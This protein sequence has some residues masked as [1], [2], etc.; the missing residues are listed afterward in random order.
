MAR[1][2][3]LLGYGNP[4]LDIQVNGTVEFLNKYD[5]RPNNAILAEEKHKPMF[6]DMVD[7]FKDTEYIPGGATQNAIKV[8]Q[9]IIGI[10]NATTFFGCISKDKFGMIL[11][12]KAREAGVNVKYQYTDK[13]GTGTCGVIVTA[14]NRSLCANL[15]AANCFTEDHLDNPENWKLVEKAEFFYIAGFPLTVCPPAILRIAKHACEK[16]KVFCMNLSAPFLC[17]FYKEPMLQVLPYV[18][19][20]FGNESEAEAFAKENNFNTTDVKEIAQKITEWKKENKNR[21]RTVVIT[22]GQDPTIVA[23][24]GKVEEY[25]VIP[26]EQKDIVDC[27]GAGDAFVGGFLAQL[28]ARKSIAEC[29]RCGHY[30]ANVIIKRSG[31]TFPEKPSFVSYE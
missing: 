28:V 11:E 3:I 19:I 29:I 1:E 22:Q 20:L 15:G 17:Q 21:K 4:L 6:K 25:P 16:N 18:D 13:E 7:T 2:G 8:A 23:A 26:I 27:N 31:C 5:L 12:E 10:P 30:A 24:D 9:W 14:D